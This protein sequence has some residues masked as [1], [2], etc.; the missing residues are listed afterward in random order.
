MQHHRLSALSLAVAC[1]L[2]VIGCGGKPP[3]SAAAAT[4]APASPTNGAATAF[5][6]AAATLAGTWSCTGSVYGAN[7]TASPSQVG[8][9]V[10][11]EL[12][13][14]WLRTDFAVLSGEHRY[15]FRSYRTFDTPS[16][17]WV[18]VILDNM[19]GHAMSRSADGVTWT[20]ESSGPMGTMKIQDTETLA[21][22]GELAIAGRYSLD[23]ASWSTG[24]D[25]ACRK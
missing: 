1:S 7:G 15:E 6:E 16:R 2:V 14:A 9:T 3:R 8:L 23:G 24:Y 21:P 25:L 13:E 17:Q 20:G 5:V 10:T 11:L 19:R 12:D 18:N 22:T 4:S